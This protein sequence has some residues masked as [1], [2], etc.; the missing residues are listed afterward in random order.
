[1]DE[2]GDGKDDGIGL[3]LRAGFCLLAVFLPLGLCLEVLHGFK[4][5]V[6]LGSPMRRELWTLAHM[7]GNFLGLLLLAWA[8]VAPRWLAPADRLPVARWLRRGAVLLPV[9]FFLGGVGNSE[10]D[11]SLAILLVPVGALCLLVGLVLVLLRGGTR[12]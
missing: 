10:G 9:G 6:Y 11:P 7:H 2:P 5:P 12:P 8:A 4:V 1:M 3:A